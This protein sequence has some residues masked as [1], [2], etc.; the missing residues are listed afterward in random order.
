MANR[1]FGCSDQL[2]LDSFYDS[3]TPSMT[4]EKDRE[5]KT[6]WG[7]GEKRIMNI[8]HRIMNVIHR[9]M[10][11]IQGIMN[12]IDR[13]VNIIHRIM[14]VIQRIMNATHKDGSFPNYKSN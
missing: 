8:I 2:L 4:E 6:S 12:V 10:K 5:E 7:T 1:V 14:N 3:S 11:F 9:I 13:I